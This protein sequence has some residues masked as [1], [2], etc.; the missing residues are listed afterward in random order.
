MTESMVAE[1][2][3]LLEIRDL[4]VSFRSD[5]RDMPV[6]RG[7]NL[8]VYPGQTVAIVGESG[9]GKS[10]T[11]HAI[12]DL[13]PGPGRVT[14]GEI[15]FGGTDLTRIGATELRAVRGRRIGL[16]PQDP[17]SNLNP[18]W[19]I[20]FQIEETLAAHGIAKGAAARARAAELLA[21]AG[22]A[23]AANRLGQ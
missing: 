10:T 22:I 6:V 21:E 19:T 4:H 18:V 17:M 13:L 12:I 11:A 7:V 16:V 23:D 20:G 9:S 2:V 5:G 3:P 14:G 15:R 1:S 8:T